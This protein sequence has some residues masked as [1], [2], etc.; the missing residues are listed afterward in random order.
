[1]KLL[2]KDYTNWVNNLRSG[3]YTQ[4]KSYLKTDEGYCCLGVLCE[5]LGLPS[6][7]NKYKVFGESLNTSV[8]PTIQIGYTLEH[9]LI[10]LN[11]NGIS[12]DAIADII[13]HRDLV[14]E[15]EMDPTLYYEDEHVR[16]FLDNLIEKSS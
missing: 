5:T 8:A 14:L 1:M 2:D 16:S 10:T 6:V 12:F 15:A 13:E 9:I 7:A 11:D 3:E 4:D